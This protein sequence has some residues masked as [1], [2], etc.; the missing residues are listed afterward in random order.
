M[1]PRRVTVILELETDVPLRDLRTAS[2][3]QERILTDEADAVMDVE[4]AQVNVTKSVE[5]ST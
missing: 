3:W 4:R 1:N 5:E 2:W